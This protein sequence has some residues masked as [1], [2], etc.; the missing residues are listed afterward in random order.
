MS[1]LTINFHLFNPVVRKKK[2][3]TIRL[4][5]NS[6]HE[7]CSL[8]LNP[9][10]S[11]DDS[12]SSFLA[13][14]HTHA[15]FYRTTSMYPCLDPCR[16]KY[17]RKNSISFQLNRCLSITMMSERSQ[18]LVDGLLRRKDLCL[19]VALMVDEQQDDD[20]QEETMIEFLTDKLTFDDQDTTSWQQWL[21]DMDQVWR[22]STRFL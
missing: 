14:A 17:K 7:N 4:H 20:D 6:R 8:A 16:K 12:M 5:P 21:V 19:W 1:E 13:D 15:H 3:T 10:D 11:I 2:T 9:L 18:S 22:C